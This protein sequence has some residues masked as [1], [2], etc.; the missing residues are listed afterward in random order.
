[1]ALRFVLGRAG[2]GKTHHCLMSI[3][4]ELA[5]GADGPALVLLVPE[6]ATFQVE[7]SLLALVPG[8]ARA[9][10][11]SFRRLAWRV[12]Q[13]LGGQARPAVGELG[14]R[15]VLRSV[16]AAEA[17]NLRAF[18]SVADRPGFIER[19]SRTLSELAS[20][21]IDPARVAAEGLLAAK[22]HDLT[23]LRERYQAYLEGRFSDP[24]G[25]LDRL[26]DALPASA[27]LR[28]ARVWVDGFAGF[29]AQELRVLQSLVPVAAEVQVA[30]L[31]DPD[32]G[33]QAQSDG[34][35]PTLQTRQ[36]LLD[37]G[38]PVAEPIVLHATPRFRSPALAHLERELFHFPGR[39]SP[40]GADG[41]QL[42]V[43]PTR[44]AEVDAVGAEI[45]RLVR[46]EGHRY[47]DVAVV[48]R[49][50]DVYLDLL[51]STF[52]ALAI[53]FFVD[54]RRPVA[55]H[56]LVELLRS[57]LE[58]VAGRW[59][60]DA[61]LRY[62]KTDLVPVDRDDVDRLETHVVEFGIR[63]SVWTDRRPWSHR[64]R[65][66]LEE[67][68]EPAPADAARLVEIDRIRVVAVAQLAAFDAR[69]A[70]L[71][72]G[73]L[74]V[75]ELSAAVYALLVDLGVPERILAW[76]REAERRGDLEQSQ[77][78]LQV[79][80]GVVDLL[81]QTVES[82]PDLR[83]SPADYLKVIASGLDGLRIGLVPPGL[84]QVVVGGVE[85]SRQPELRALFVLGANE[86]SFP[87]GVEE[88]VVFNDAE[89]QQLQ[90]AGCALE[91]DSRRRALNEQYL[92]YVALTRASERLWIGR[93]A[94]DDDGRALPAALV[95]RRLQAL[96]PGIV[97]RLVAA[98][99]EEPAACVTAPRLI[100]SLARR[101]RRWREGDAVGEEWLD[102][103]EWLLSDP[104]LSRAAR[105]VLASLAYRGRFQP[106]A[107]DVARG[108]YGRDVVASVSQMERYAACAFQH[109]AVHGLRLRERAVQRLEASQLGQY[110]HAA[111][112]LGA[113]R[114]SQRG[115][116]WGGLD[117]TAAG[118]LLDEVLAELAP[119]LQNEILASSG[120]YRQVQR[121]A[122]RTLEAVAST[123]GEHDRRGLF[124]PA[125]VEVGFGPRADDR[126]APLGIELPDGGRLRLGGRI[127]RVDLA[128]VGGRRLLR[129][130]DFKSSPRELRPDRV[131]HGLALQ[132]AVYLMAAARGWEAEPAG[133]LYLPVHDPIEPIDRPGAAPA[134]R[135]RASGWV[136]ADPEVVRAMDA[137]AGGD[138]VPVRLKQDGQPYSNAPTFTPQG[139]QALFGHIERR[140]AG[141]GAEIGAGSV[142]AAPYRIDGET[143]CRF[144]PFHGVCGFDPLVP[145]HAYRSLPK[146]GADEVWQ[147]LDG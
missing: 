75:P 129:V 55:H 84:D 124:R 3:A 127:D 86:G 62:L 61:V 28:G 109:F 122:R 29:T 66:T 74:P 96:F 97:P 7:R 72:R 20:Y 126:L 52:R 32:A 35:Q 140:L 6:Q 133:L 22:L 82:L 57:A 101:L 58:A 60:A 132:L 128:E 116:S 53:P 30:L 27:A 76:S 125:A 45:V 68:E 89:R 91:P 48:V 69:L 70:G 8:F 145:G 19:L 50:L 77:E 38:L 56:P 16:V 99:E 90:A 44:R 79:W 34:F 41:L 139:L 88:D 21:R 54:Q 144:C 1:M 141:F 65:F 102:A 119:R 113:R 95:V 80:Q 51:T 112:S 63:G 2:S 71:G 26:A 111:L 107:P 117:A 37:L 23:L 5:R 108:L 36:Q 106:I 105:P 12:A 131:F 43:A 98:G 42:V 138:L 10:V 135:Q 31:L 94:V 33:R 134:R 114:L 67:D 39:R 100:A 147:R 104:Q 40:A 24:D 83:L 115:Q 142:A 136:L 103:Y 81:D 49:D 11:T 13:E 78:H 4:A 14:R 92:T 137:A 123:L 17:A 46:D 85:R 118:E 47:R 73:A 146:L 121:V 143:P 87:P 15:M 93:P 120:R 110:Y 59:P 18:G 130:V 9:Q 64:R 25:Q